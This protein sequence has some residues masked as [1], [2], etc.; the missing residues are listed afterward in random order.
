MLSDT[1]IHAEMIAPC[2]ID[3]G[4]CSA[5]LRENKP[6]PGCRGSDEHKLAHCITCSIRNCAELKL[7]PASFCVGCEKFACVRLKRLDQ[8]YRIQYSTGLIANLQTIAAQGME[9]FLKQEQTQWECA[10]CGGVISVHTG[11]CSQCGEKKSV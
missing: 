11:K 6:C 2:G 5:H 1:F 3:C 8:R 9:T 7:A 10:Q 4:I